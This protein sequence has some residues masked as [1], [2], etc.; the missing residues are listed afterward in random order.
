MYSES[1]QQMK[2]NLF[3]PL[4]ISVLIKFTFFS[5]FILIAKKK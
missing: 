1:M 2:N 4:E 3:I 5:N